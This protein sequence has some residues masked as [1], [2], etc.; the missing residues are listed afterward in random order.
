MTITEGEVFRNTTDG[1]DFIVRKVV[2]DMVV[3]RSRDGKRQII[4][5]MRTLT[6]TPFY[7]KKG[8]EES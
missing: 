8:E 2:N 1:A 7:Q 3:L 4:T 5:E 6:S